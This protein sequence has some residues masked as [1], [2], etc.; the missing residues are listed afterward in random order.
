MGKCVVKWDG[1]YLSSQGGKHGNPENRSGHDIKF[2]KNE[3]KAAERI[4][5]VIECRGS[6]RATRSKFFIIPIGGDNES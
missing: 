5:R 4:E 6:G 3:K 2:F 1:L